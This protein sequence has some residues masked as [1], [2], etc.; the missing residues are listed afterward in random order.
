[1]ATSTVTPRRR[2]EY[3]TYRPPDAGGPGQYAPDM[4]TGDPYNMIQDDRR[5]IYDR[6]NRLDQDLRD[7]S[8]YRD[9]EEGRYGAAADSAY[10]NLMDTPGYTAEEAA[11]IQ[12]T[13]QYGA[14]PTDQAD[15]DA[16]YQTEAEQAGATG[17]TNSYYGWFDPA[18]QEGIDR[19]AAQWQ[20]NEYRGGVDRMDTATDQQDTAMQGATDPTRLRLDA[21]YGGQQM[22]AVGGME[23]NVRGAI[24]P[25]KLS[26]SDRFQGNYP[27][28]DQDVEMRATEGAQRVGNQYRSAIGEM[29]QSALEAGNASPMAVAA[30]RARLERQS[31]SDAALASL[32]L[33]NAA[34]TEQAQREKDLESMRLGAEGSQ[35]G[36]RAES[37]LALGGQRL[38]AGQDV[39]GR[40]IAAEQGY[41]DRA[42][43]VASRTGDARRGIG[44]F[45][46]TQ[47]VGMEAGIG[48]QAAGTQQ[49]ITDRGT[50]IATDKD[51]ADVD[52]SRY[53]YEARRGTQQ[54][55]NDTKF[56][57]GLDVTDRQAAGSQTVADARRAGEGEYRG[58]VA[59]SRN[60]QA[61]LGSTTRDQRIKN[62]G[63]QAGATN[64]ATQTMGS[65]DLARR[66]QSF[67]T[68]FKSTL[69]QSLGSLPG[70][71]SYS[72]SKGFGMG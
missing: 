60:T 35:A 2:L 39:E 28:S 12:M 31:A 63:T 26:L 62:Y 30:A 43:D 61:G 37:E 16:M 51:A 41:T 64:D 65:Y 53:N 44:E 56:G 40:R 24:D 33:K 14:L 3:P 52:R 25:S 9:A 50:Q 4:K 70:K 49:Y 18:Q 34:R 29:Q 19:D 67:G 20:R 13:E 1:M 68:N 69:G 10:D 71:A 58:Y 17:D 22:D 6:G 46:G 23:S 36:M 45:T 66:G 55:G 27:M 57:Q 72:K 59:D 5:V 8:Q 32:S 15:I 47:G 38:A 11:G 7:T 21:G 54:Y 48:R 42:V